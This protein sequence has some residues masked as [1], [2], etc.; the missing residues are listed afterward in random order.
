MREAAEA[1]GRRPEVLMLQAPAAVRRRQ[2]I[3]AR[4]MTQTHATAVQPGLAVGT[5]NRLPMQLITHG[6]HVQPEARLARQRIP[7]GPAEPAEPAAAEAAVAGAE[8]R[9][10]DRQMGLNRRASVEQVGPLAMPAVHVLSTMRPGH[11]RKG[12]RMRGSEILV[13]HQRRGHVVLPRAEWRLQ[14]IRQTPT[15]LHAAEP[16]LA[17]Q[18]RVLVSG[19]PLLHRNHAA[20]AVPTLLRL[21]VPPEGRLWR[22]V[23]GRVENCLP[24]WHHLLLLLLVLL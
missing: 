4:A 3:G 22:V 12:M 7:A 16:G 19:L 14:V 9:C 15:A 21:H 5:A 11:V 13:L 18:R 24:R 10:R 6:L 23:L 8:V 1:V 17:P 2:L 20:A